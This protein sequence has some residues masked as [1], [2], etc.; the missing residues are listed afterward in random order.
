MESTWRATMI[1]FGVSERSSAILSQH[2][3]SNRWP[4][5]LRFRLWRSPARDMCHISGTQLRSLHMRVLSIVAAIVML[6]SPLTARASCDTGAP[7][8][9]RDIT[10]VKVE[11]FSLVGQQ[12]PW[13]TY[14]AAYFTAGRRADVSLDAHR[15]VGITGSFVSTSPLDSFKNVVHVLKTA[16]FFAMRLHP[17]SR[18]YLDGPEDSITATRCGVSTVLTTAPPSEEPNLDDAQGKAFFALL[19]DLRTAIFSRKWTAPPPHSSS[20]GSS[21]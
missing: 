11:Q 7:P 20:G 21:P 5:R 2:D 17:T 14:T 1:S 15:A 8:A 9:Y 12:H 16:R 10:Y 13:Y 18:L 3:M 6:S 19:K 4:L